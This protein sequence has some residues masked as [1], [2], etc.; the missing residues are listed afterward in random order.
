MKAVLVLGCNAG[1]RDVA[2]KNAIIF[3]ASLGVI[4]KCSDIYE[5]PDCLGIGKQYL[6]MVIELETALDES[7]LN[8]RLKNYEIACGRDRDMRE[9]GEVPMDIDLVIW[10]GEVRRSSD[11]GAS[12]FRRGYDHMRSR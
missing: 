12:Y 6:N 1:R 9:R 10:E 3:V 5:T 11:F 4:L 7:S 2:L 8:L